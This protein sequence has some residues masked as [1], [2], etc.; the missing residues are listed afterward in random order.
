ME[1]RQTDRRHKKERNW[2]LPTCRR[3]VGLLGRYYEGLNLGLRGS[4]E[5][6]NRVSE[7]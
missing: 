7:F 2:Q 6:E 1:E 5:I 4:R 3:S